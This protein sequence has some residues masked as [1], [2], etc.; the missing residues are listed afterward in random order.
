MSRSA[1][2]RY[3]YDNFVSFIGE[4]GRDTGWSF[5]DDIVQPNWNYTQALAIDKAFS[6]PTK[7]YGWKIRM[8]NDRGEEGWV[9]LQVWRPKLGGYDHIGSTN[10]TFGPGRGSG[11]TDTEVLLQPGDQIPVEQGDIIGLFL[12]NGTRGV[13]FALGSS[14]TIRDSS[15]V[16]FFELPDDQDPPTELVTIDYDE[17]A[18]QFVVNVYAMTG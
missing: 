13:P 2:C 5:Q 7:V 9:L 17:H 12:P 10:L 11:Y 6:Y 3:S 15:H 14:S 16:I 18:T 4:R 8:I 1:C